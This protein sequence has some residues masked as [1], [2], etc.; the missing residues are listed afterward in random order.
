MPT[1]RDSLPERE[2]QHATIL[3]EIK[4][5][6]PRHRWYHG[7]QR[8]CQRGRVFAK[9]QRRNEPGYT[10]VLPSRGATQVAHG[11]SQ[12]PHQHKED[13]QDQAE[14]DTSAGQPA[15]CTAFAIVLPGS[16]AAQGETDPGKEGVIDIAKSKRSRVYQKSLHNFAESGSRGQ[17]AAQK[18]N[19]ST[20]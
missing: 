16:N 5:R 8:I 3:V 4:M 18:T 9:S 12:S 10:S 14:H 2:T 17:W 6:Y 13:E 7:P 15:A 11:S 19:A 20:P 1:R